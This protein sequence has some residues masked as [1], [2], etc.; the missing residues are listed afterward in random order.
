[1]INAWMNS[2]LA[3]QKKKRYQSIMLGHLQKLLVPLF[4]IMTFIIGMYCNI[5]YNWYDAVKLKAGNN[6]PIWHGWYPPHITVLDNTGEAWGISSAI[7]GND[8]Q[9]Q[10]EDVFTVLK[11]I[12]SRQRFSYWF[13]YFE[14]TMTSMQLCKTMR[15]LKIL[16][17]LS[18]T[19]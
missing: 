9:R 14:S 12:F 8:Y 4:E 5:F 15:S 18:K 6:E 13:S 10:V 2:V 17:E 16:V 19:M 11:F 1:M 7:K 3:S